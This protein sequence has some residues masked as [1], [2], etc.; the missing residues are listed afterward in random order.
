VKDVDEVGARSE[1]SGEGM[2]E[3]GKSDGNN[4]FSGVTEWLIDYMYRENQ[5]SEAYSAGK[6]KPFPFI[7]SISPALKVAFRIDH[8]ISRGLCVQDLRHW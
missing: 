3:A 2:S 7:S 8:T 5:L 6:K 1:W 4:G